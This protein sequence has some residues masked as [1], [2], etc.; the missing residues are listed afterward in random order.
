MNKSFRVDTTMVDLYANQLLMTTDLGIKR[1]VYNY[2]T[3]L[4]LFAY[5]R[6]A[7]LLSSRAKHS[8]G[9][10]K[11]S[12]NM[13]L[14][15]TSD[16]MEGKVTVGKNYEVPYQR[17][18]EYGIKIR[19]TIVGKPLMAFRASKWPKAK[20]A[21]NSKGY[22]VFHMVK[23]GRFKGLRYIR[24]SYH[25]VKLVAKKLYKTQAIPEIKRVIMPRG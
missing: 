23:R 13:N 9:H 24:D 16:Y 6:V 25:T 15:S 10:I 2:I 1:S 22:Y 17:A 7:Y 21:P 14:K 8:T 12:I 5:K 3:A 11:G 18:L 19:K 4:T 20:T